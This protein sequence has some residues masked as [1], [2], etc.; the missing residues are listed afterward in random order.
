MSLSCCIYRVQRVVFGDLVSHAARE[1]QFLE[2]GKKRWQ[3]VYCKLCRKQL[4]SVGNTTNLTSHLKNNHSEDYHDCQTEEKGPVA[5]E[6]TQSKP[7]S[8]KDAFQA[9]TPRWKKLTNSVYYFIA[10]DGQPLDRYRK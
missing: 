7:Q 1:G 6:A 5:V 9:M 8:I 4:S 3:Q 2:K 10:K